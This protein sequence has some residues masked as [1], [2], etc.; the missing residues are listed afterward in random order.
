MYWITR[1]LAQC[2]RS[3]MAVR[4]GMFARSGRSQGQPLRIWW[5]RRLGSR[6]RPRPGSDGQ[7][8]APQPELSQNFGNGALAHAVCPGTRPQA[9][10]RHRAKP[11]PRD[12]PLR[13]L[14]AGPQDLDQSSLPSLV[15][16][17]GA[18]DRLHLLSNL[19][20]WERFSRSA[21]R[22]QSA[23]EGESLEW[24]RICQQICE[25]PHSGTE[26]ETA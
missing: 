14:T 25:M 4:G 11:R 15:R 1:V 9:R 18:P 22:S 12:E 20:G 7:A 5:R 17:T 16:A 3:S 10:P 6:R 23:S 21:D 24:V 8:P 2:C 19:V 26:E 13:S